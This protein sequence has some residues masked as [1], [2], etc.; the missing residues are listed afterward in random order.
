M[1]DFEDLAKAGAILILGAIVLG[2]STIIS[3]GLSESFLDLGFFMII[4]AFVIAII[5][6]LVP[7][8]KRI[9]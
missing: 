9:F 4:M 1:T 3:V 8:M 7:I 6:V 2:S 5:S